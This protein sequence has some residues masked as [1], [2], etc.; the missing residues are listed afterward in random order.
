MTRTSHL[1]CHLVRWT[2]GTRDGVD[3]GSRRAESV[4]RVCP[5]PGSAVGPL[6]LCH[7]TTEHVHAPLCCHGAR[8]EVAV[9]RRGAVAV[10]TVT[11]QSTE[12]GWSHIRVQT[13]LMNDHRRQVRLT[14]GKNWQLR[15]PQVCQDMGFCHGWVVWICSVKK[16]RTFALVARFRAFA[17]K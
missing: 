15:R 17:L 14:S 6:T 7:V 5:L 9:W 4:L 13:F 3:E 16:I 10:S 12:A 11:S 8:L 1:V 2:A